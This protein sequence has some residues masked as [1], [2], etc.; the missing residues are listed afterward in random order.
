[1]TDAPSPSAKAVDRAVELLTWISQWLKENPN[2][3]RPDELRRIDFETLI[4]L[5]PALAAARDQVK[6]LTRDCQTLEM[7]YADEVALRISH[8]GLIEKL[9]ARTTAIEVGQTVYV[10]MGND[11]PAG[12]MLNQAKADKLCKERNEA[13]K[14]DTGQPFALVY[15][16]ATTF[17]L[18]GQAEK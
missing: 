9:K 17:I 3:V 18:G 8:E 5:A 16:K 6:A 1:M 4:L 15:W 13:Q 11:F 12:V 14:D 10:I 2:R 7:A